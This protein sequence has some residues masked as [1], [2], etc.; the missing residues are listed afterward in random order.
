MQNLKYDTNKLIYKT[1]T[2]LQTQKLIP[3]EKR[4][5]DKLGVWDQQI[6]T[7]VYKMNN[8]V[9]LYSTRNYI[10]YLVINHN[11]KEYEKEYIYI[12]IFFIYITESLHR[13]PETNTTL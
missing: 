4:G 2:D 5:R 8:E 6:Q 9:L 7:T 11:G 1:E 10:Q 13:T 3:K 12:Y